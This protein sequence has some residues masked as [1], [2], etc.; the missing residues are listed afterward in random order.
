MPWARW[1]SALLEQVS[2]A[3]CIHCIAAA[4]APGTG[5]RPYAR[6]D[7]S[8]LGHLGPAQRR[9]GPQRLGLGDAL[10]AAS[11]GLQTMSY[12]DQQG[13]PLT[14][15]SLLPLY[16]ALIQSAYTIARLALQCILLEAA[17]EHN[18]TLGMKCSLA[19]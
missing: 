11:G 7:P 18:V 4:R 14:R 9:K 3:Y 16:Q 12:S 5:V 19:E 1:T 10:A 8:R 6:A 2:A 13:N 15:F 17:G